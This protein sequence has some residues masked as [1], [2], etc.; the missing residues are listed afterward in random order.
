MRQI[1]QRNLRLPIRIVEFTTKEVDGRGLLRAL[2]RRTRLRL[3]RQRRLLVP[4]ACRT[5]FRQLSHQAVGTSPC[6]K[7]MCDDVAKAAH[8][9]QDI[10]I[11]WQSESESETGRWRH[12]TVVGGGQSCYHRIRTVVD[13]T[14]V[15]RKLNCDK[16]LQRSQTN[17]WEMQK[18]R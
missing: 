8:S 17:H 11:G 3:A 6:L 7:G 13:G 1:P 4:A 16:S 14:S 10:Y 12:T 2:L 9:Y 18:V 15:P 5:P